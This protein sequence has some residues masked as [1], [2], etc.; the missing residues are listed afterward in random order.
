MNYTL[1]YRQSKIIGPTD[2]L[3]V[4]YSVPVSIKSEVISKDLLWVMK[5]TLST[6]GVDPKPSLIK[7]SSIMELLDSESPI[8]SH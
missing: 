4:D 8:N 6:I 5:R 3:V 7:K 2:S 1:D